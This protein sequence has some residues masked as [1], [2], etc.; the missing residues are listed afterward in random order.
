[1]KKD[2]EIAKEF[3]FKFGQLS[4]LVIDEIL[5]A[6]VKYI[7]IREK[8]DYSK[9]GFDNVVHNVYDEK[10]LRVKKILEL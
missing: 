8:V 2:I 10:W 1:M 3:K 4:L 9:T 5:E 6:T 7:A